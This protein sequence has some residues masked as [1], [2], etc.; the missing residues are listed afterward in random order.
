MKKGFSDAMFWP[1]QSIRRIEQWQ[2]M[3]QEGKTFST[4][5]S[6]NFSPVNLKEID[7]I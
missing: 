4:N 1:F 3:S 7:C 2:L 6:R 5:A